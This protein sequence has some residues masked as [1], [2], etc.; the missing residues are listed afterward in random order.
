M[1]STG[2]CLR[3]AFAQRPKKPYV[4]QTAAG[5]P[6][7]DFEPDA[8]AVFTLP[9]GET[10]TLKL[11]DPSGYDAERA[12]KVGDILF[13]IHSCPEGENARPNFGTYTKEALDR[14][15]DAVSRIETSKV[16]AWL[17]TAETEDVERIDKPAS[18]EAPKEVAAGG[19]SRFRRRGALL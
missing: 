10:A 12:N 8:V 1:A 11:S 14:N 2:Q 18:R 7:Q 19:G 5:A 9:S 17:Q 3:A 4:L 6:L 15:L 16:I 13:F